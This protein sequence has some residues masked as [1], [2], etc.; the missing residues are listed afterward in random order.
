MSSE[1]CVRDNNNYSCIFKSLLSIIHGTGIFMYRLNLILAPNRLYL[2][3]ENE[4][5]E[6]VER[7]GDMGVGWS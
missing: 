1:Y 5:T 3:H 7:E 6:R 2:N 4:G